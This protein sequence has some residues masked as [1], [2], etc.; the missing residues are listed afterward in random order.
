M[1]RQTFS[2]RLLETLLSKSCMDDAYQTL[3]A[4]LWD[5]TQPSKLP[6]GHSNHPFR[7]VWDRLSID[8]ELIVL[9][10]YRF[11]IPASCCKQL[12]SHLHLTHASITKTLLLCKS[13]YYWP[14]LKKE[15]MDLIANFEKCIKFKDSQPQV[16]MLPSLLFGKPSQAF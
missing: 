16:V 3:L 7:D 6:L 5:N 2:E 9:D 15:V 12:L 4:A 14:N 11:I 13:R 1:I 8:N 10:G